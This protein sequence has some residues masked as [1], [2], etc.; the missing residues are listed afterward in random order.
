VGDKAKRDFIRET[1]NKHQIDFLGLQETMRQTFTQEILLSLSGGLDLD[2]TNSPARGRFGGILVG[3]N[4]SS[5]CILQREIG[6]YFVR[7]LL[8]NKEDNFFWNLIIVYG[9]AQ[10]TGKVKFLIELV[11]V[12]RKS[13]APLVIAGD[14]NMTRR[15]SDKNKPGGYNKWSI[16]FNSVISQGELMEIK[17]SGRQFTWSNNHEDPTYELLDRV[18]VSPSWEE[19][20]PLVTVNALSRVLSDHTPLLLSTGDKARAPPVFRFENCWL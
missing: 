20:Y 5:C 1:S 19:K 8:C 2:W 12:I 10:Q 11:H 4:K 18:I 15:E 16:L 3:I 14:F 7:I 13:H 9:D 17:L 6:D